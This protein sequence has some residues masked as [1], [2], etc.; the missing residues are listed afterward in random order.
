MK[1]IGIPV[2]AFSRE[3]DELAYLQMPKDMNVYC[4][5]VLPEPEEM[6][7]GARAVLSFILDSLLGKSNSPISLN[8]LSEKERAQVGQV[9]G[10]GEVSIRMDGVSIQES[11]LAGI[12]QIR[13]DDEVRIEVCPF[14]EVVARRRKS[15]AFRLPASH[16]E[17]VMNSP[18]VLAEIAAKSVGINEEPHVVNLSLLPMNRADIDHLDN[19]LGRGDI[20]ILS[21]GYGNC[22]IESTAMSRVWRVRYFNSQDALILDTIEVVDIPGVAMAARE[23]LEDSGERLLEIIEWVGND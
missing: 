21:R 9:L 14:P 20:V 22:R 11:V 7:E 13:E 18:S 8:A 10:E 4:A 23:D 2:R 15:A 1:P 19:V 12:W 16:P 3:E 17:G 5:P 6:S